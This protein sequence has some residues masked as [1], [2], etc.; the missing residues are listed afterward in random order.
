MRFSQNPLA[1]GRRL[2][3][4]RE[5]GTSFHCL[6]GSHLLVSLSAERS[7]G[8][9]TN[10]PH[11]IYA[12]ADQS[13]CAASGSCL[14]Q[15]FYAV[16]FEAVKFSSFAEMA[17]ALRND[18]IQAAF[19]I[20]PLAVVLRQ[21]GVDVKVVLIGN[22][23]ESTLVARKTLGAKRLEDLAGSTIAVPMRFSGHNICLLKQ[24]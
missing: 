6:A 7:A 15:W 11:G 3:E 1:G 24:H 5:T 22:R 13:G 10:G 9:Q 14:P 18:S 23:N 4:A 21:Q 8:R 20:A 16:F 17:E 12:G 2:S 19:I